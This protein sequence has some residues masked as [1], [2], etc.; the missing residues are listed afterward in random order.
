MRPV[1]WM[2]GWFRR[3]HLPRESIGLGSDPHPRELTIWP[4]AVGRAEKSLGGE[5]RRFTFKNFIHEIGHINAVTITLQ[6][7]CQ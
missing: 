5:S 1:G 3:H 4:V 2:S 6:A 7:S